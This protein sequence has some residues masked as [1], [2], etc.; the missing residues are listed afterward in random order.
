M[1]KKKNGGLL[2][3]LG[4]LLSS[5]ASL[6]L[7][8]LLIL[9]FIALWQGWLSL[10]GLFGM[11]TITNKTIIE[12]LDN[13]DQLGKLCKLT[14]NP[15]TIEPGDTLNGQFK[16]ISGL[17]CTLYGNMKQN[18][19]W[20]GWIQITEGNTDVTGVW[21]ASEEFWLEGEFKFVVD[22]Q[23][24]CTSNEVMVTVSE[25]DY[26]SDSDGGR[27]VYVWGYAD[28]S[29]YQTSTPDTCLDNHAVVEAICED[30]HAT[31]VNVMCQLGEVCDDG[32]CIDS[33]WSPG[34][35]IT[36]GGGSGTL[37]QWGGQDYQIDLS[38][39]GLGDNEIGA[40]VGRSWSYA[41]DCEETDATV[42]FF[43]FDSVDMRWK[44]IDVTPQNNLNNPEDIGQ[45]VWDGQTPFLIEVYNHK[46]CMIDYEVKVILY[47]M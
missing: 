46:P 35:T 19:Q 11:D 32:V 37:G 22:C 16:G 29:Y 7:V 41:M 9:F 6:L 14:I 17:N 34:E 24:Y 39:Y 3:S 12:R 10:D 21:T 45:V 36:I 31:T 26:C 28:D 44:A 4:S 38:K 27:D 43:F 42:E 13:P 33:G 47:V 15:T 8:L 25:Q 5:V 40:K 1:T 18:D 23:N 2:A 20:T 30:G